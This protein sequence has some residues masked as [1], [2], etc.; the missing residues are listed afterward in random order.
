MK[1]TVFPPNSPPKDIFNHHLAVCDESCPKARHSS[2]MRA[3][4]CTKHSSSPA[5]WAA[6]LF[7]SIISTSLTSLSP[8]FHIALFPL[9]L[10]LGFLCCPSPQFPSPP[11]PP[12]PFPKHWS[13]IKLNTIPGKVCTCFLSSF[14]S[15]NRC[16]FNLQEDITIHLL[17]CCCF[18][19]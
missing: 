18:C 19:W 13:Q 5:L 10:S 4:L 15:L 8:F 6:I 14:L 12:T 11:P 9:P 7:P 2:C 1:A 16:F 3:S 17:D